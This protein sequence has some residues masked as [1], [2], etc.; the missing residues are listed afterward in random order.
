M[1]TETTGYWIRENFPHTHTIHIAKNTF[2]HQS[3]PLAISKLI[4]ITPLPKVD[5]SAFF[6]LVSE[7]SQMPTS[8]HVLSE[9]RWWFVQAA[10]LLKIT[11]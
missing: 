3:V 4:V 6:R 8:V 2:H 7:A 5:W 11:T 9:C 10:T 1:Y